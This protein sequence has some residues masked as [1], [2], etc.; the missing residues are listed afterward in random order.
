MNLSN[1]VLRRW[2]LLVLAGGIV[3]GLSLG[4]RQSQ[5]LFMLPVS[6]GLDW[7][8]EDVGFAFA[9][10]NLI[11][12]LTQP[13]TGMIADRFGPA[14][15]IFFG[16]LLYAAGLFAMARASDLLLFNLNAGVLVGIGLA[17]TAFG[18]IYSAVSK[19]VPPRDRPWA[20]GAV[21]AI[22][23]TVQFLVVP[24]VHEMLNT[25]AWDGT[26]LV[27][28][29][30][31]LAV[32]PLAWLLRT[33]GAE[34]VATGTDAPTMGAAIYEALR[35]R[36]FWLLLLGFTASGFQLAFLSG[37]VP[38]YLVDRGVPLPVAGT[39]IA[40]ISL[41]NIVGAFV[42][43]YVGGPVF[44]RKYTLAFLY[45]CRTL[46]MVAFISVP[47]TPVSTYLFAGMIGFLWLG[48]VPLTIGLIGQIF[49][50]RYLT[51][52]FGF[53]FLGHQLGAFFGIWLA[54]YVFD[55]TG[56]YSSIWWLSIGAGALAALLHM[57]INDRQLAR[58]TSIEA[59]PA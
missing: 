44:R 48:S 25:R 2:G 19:I 26:F 9:L 40:L 29:V 30:L 11:W 21:G 55:T 24:F 13:L 52:L 41:T 8:I 47:L 3:M 15:V 12:G 57:P 45:T 33:R 50:G 53:A 5:A 22:G 49:G 14:R 17:G 7:A 46:A 20:I 38:S 34:E 31:L 43:G 32:C 6:M 16:V 59:V 54:G 35:H 4:T 36:G 18:V 42:F 23:A 51:T 27:L 58:R 56:S 28:A 10:Q 1:G 39:A 37:N